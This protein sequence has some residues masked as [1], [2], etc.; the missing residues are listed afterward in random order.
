[1][2]ASRVD[3]HPEPLTSTE[4]TVLDAIAFLLAERGT[5]VPEITGESAIHEDLGFDSLELAELSVRL[6]DQLGRD[7]YSAGVQPRTVGE[8]LAFYR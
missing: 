6:E 7:P 8:L 5:D 1:M 2:A 4:E 3:Q